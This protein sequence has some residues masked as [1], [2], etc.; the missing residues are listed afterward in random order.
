MTEGTNSKLKKKKKKE[1]SIFVL[2]CKFYAL[3]NYNV[4]VAHGTTG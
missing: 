2:T 4:K 1:N 3:I